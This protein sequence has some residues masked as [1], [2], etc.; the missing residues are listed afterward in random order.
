MRTTQKLASATVFDSLFVLLMLL[1]GSTL[2]KVAFGQGPVAATVALLATVIAVVHGRLHLFFIKF[3]GLILFFLG[4]Q[5][6]LALLHTNY[7]IFSSQFVIFLLSIYVA[8]LASNVFYNRRFAFVR[9][10]NFWMRVLIVHALLAVVANVLLPGHPFPNLVDEHKHWR[11]IH[12]LLSISVLVDYTGQELPAN[13]LGLGLERAHGLFTEP[14]V[15]VNYVALFL[16]LNLFVNFH[17]KNLA[18]GVLAILAAWS[19]TG[20]LLLLFLAVSYFFF[21]R[22]A[23]K[24]QFPRTFPLLRVAWF[25]LGMP[26]LFVLIF[27]N[28]TQSSYG[29]EVKQGS[30]SQRYFDTYAAALAIADRPVLGS[31]INLNNFSEALSSEEHLRQIDASLSE[32]ELVSKDQ[33]RFS[34][35]TLRLLVTFGLPIGFFLFTGLWRQGLLPRSHNTVLFGLIL[36]GTL[37]STV[38]WH[39]FYLPLLFTGLLMPRMRPHE[40]NQPAVT[41]TGL[42][43]K[44]FAVGGD[45]FQA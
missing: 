15:F 41:A 33:A 44:E 16:F 39:G 26:A 1:S 27:Q 14:G 3:F 29:T 7:S 34:N 28:L 36:L 35:S 31:G 2:A 42:T 38:L 10:Y 4:H 8:Y 13:L 17:K 11:G 32:W 18:L 19:S 45:V 30:I 6:A 21:A 37:A 22:K 5:I 9:A 25:V 23:L 24:S 12:P 40:K 20:L 43:Q